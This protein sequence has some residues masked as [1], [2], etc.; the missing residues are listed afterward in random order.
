MKGNGKKASKKGG[1]S[2]SMGIVGNVKAGKYSEVSDSKPLA[3]YNGSYKTSS[4]VKG[5]HRKTHSVGT[6]RGSH[7]KG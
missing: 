3:A 4:N 6:V 2:V 1:D 7:R 5:S